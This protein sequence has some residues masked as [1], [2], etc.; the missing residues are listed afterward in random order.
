MTTDSLASAGVDHAAGGREPR[1]VVERVTVGYK[2]DQAVLREVSA[3]VHAGRMLAITGSSGAGKTTLIRTMAASLRPSEGTVRFDGEPL[4]DRRDAIAKRIAWIP[5]HNGLATILTAAENVHVVLV[6]NG[7]SPD[8]AR[9]LTA[10]SLEAVGLAEQAGHLIEEMSGGQQQRAAIARGLALRADVV[11][12]DEITNE[13]DAGNR[14]R[15][16]ELLRAEAR[17]GAAVVLATHDPE[18]AAMCDDEL[19]LVDGSAEPV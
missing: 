2:P 8:D 14:T 7:F 11:L 6:A 5:Q 9:R 4:R 17:R 1:L 19:H 13:L 18:A 10:E 15:V 12:A 16:L 3:T